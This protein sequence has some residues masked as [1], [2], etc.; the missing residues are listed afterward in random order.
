[1]LLNNGKIDNSGTAPRRAKK[2]LRKARLQGSDRAV[3]EP[4]DYPFTT[5]DLELRS[6]SLRQALDLRATVLRVK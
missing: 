5:A 3:T 6:H 4:V 1:L 2:E